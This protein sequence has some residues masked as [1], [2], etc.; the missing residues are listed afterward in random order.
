MTSILLTLALMANPEILHTPSDG[1]TF[2]VAHGTTLGERARTTRFV[3]IQDGDPK[4]AAAVSFAVNTAISKAS[5]PIHC[6]PVAAGHLVPIEFD[7]LLPNDA[8][9]KRALELW[10]KQAGTDPYFYCRQTVKVA[11]Y[12][13]DDGKVYHYKWATA[14]GAHVD[15]KDGVLLQGM[16]LSTAPIQRADRF[17]VKTLTQIDGGNYYA[18]A[19]IRKSQKAGRSDFDQFLLDHGVDQE[20][21]R[22][23]KAERRAAVFRSGVTAKPRAIEEVQGLLGVVTYT[24]DLADNNLDPNAHPILTLLNPKFDA[25]E[26]IALRANGHCSFAL[27]NGKGELQDVVPDNITKD[28]TVPVPNTARLQ[29]GIS[30]IRCHATGKGFRTTRN[31]VQVLLK[32]QPDENGLQLDIKAYAGVSREQIDEILGKYRGNLERLNRGREDYS[33]AV[34]L[35]TRGLSVEA[36]AGIVKSIDDAYRFADVTPQVACRE[37]GIAVDEKSAVEVLR[38]LLPPIE[39]ED[40][41]TGFLRLGVSL[42]RTDWESTY[43]DNATRSRPAYLKIA[44]EQKK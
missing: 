36:V 18:W 3:W 25:T 40:G 15:A 5:Y 19:G 23:L 20:L 26:A 12:K 7:K 43:I 37:L 35:S 44:E 24:N 6:K 16:T 2:S 17:I 41:R 9:L 42:N 11:P 33:D 39:T 22:K 13:A 21:A 8:D 1:V 29:P 10:D 14:F 34:F 31:D 4:T 27:Y 28:H 38:K 30:C 32:A